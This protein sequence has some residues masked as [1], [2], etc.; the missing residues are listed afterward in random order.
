MRRSL[1]KLFSLLSHV[2]LSLTIASQ[3]A[4][5]QNA[6]GAQ[7]ANPPN[8][9]HQDLVFERLS[10]EVVFAAD[11]TGSVEQSARV[12]I[13]SDAGVQQFGVLMLPYRSATERL[14]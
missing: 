1:P 10:N 2:L 8:Y 14:E 12:R 13:Q 6:P 5:A 7:I 3:V 9:S 4:P 11:G